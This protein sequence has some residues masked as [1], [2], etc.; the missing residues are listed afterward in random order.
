MKQKKLHIAFPTPEYV[1]EPV[2]GGLATY[3]YKTTKYLKELGHEPVVMLLCNENNV[4]VHEGVTIVK[5]KISKYWWYWLGNIATFFQLNTILLTFCKSISINKMITN[6][7]HQAKISFD[8]IQYSNVQFLSSITLRNRL[9][10]LRLSQYYHEYLKYVSKRPKSFKNLQKVYLEKKC[11]QKSRSYIY[12][13][14]KLISSLV[15]KELKIE[16]PVIRTPF[17][18]YAKKTYERKISNQPYMLYFGTLTM[19]K[20]VDLFA[21]IIFDILDSHKDIHLKLVGRDT[22]IQLHRFKIPFFNKLFTEKLIES[23]YS[24]LIIKSAGTYSNRVQHYPIM[25]QRDLQQV[26]Q[27]A[28]LVILPSRIDN[29]PNTLSESLSLGKV[30][31]VANNSSLDELISHEE[32]GFIFQNGSSQ[33]LKNTI[34][35]VLELDKKSLSAISKRASSIVEQISPR[36]VIER[37]LINFYNAIIGR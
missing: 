30:V 9:Y 10:C 32:S 8:L 3:L 28:H 23:T 19:S 12:S 24:Q 31:I 18:K 16:V 34:K 29:F 17:F 21:D 26:I 1:T 22:P 27:Q 14:S 37:D 33:D 35:R 36:I 4:V 7:E 5:K 6:Y 20:G 15:E 13:P 25:K 11:I 2:Y